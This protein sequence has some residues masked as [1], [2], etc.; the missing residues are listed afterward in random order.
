MKKLI[1]A[2][3]V[4]FIGCIGSPEPRNPMVSDGVA[5]VGS[6]IWWRQPS[7]AGDPDNPWEQF[8]PQQ[9][10][11]WHDPWGDFDPEEYDIK[12]IEDKEV[13]KFTFRDE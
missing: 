3:M 9:Q 7:I 5:S 10:Q 2:C 12:P 11:K 4:L 1:L 13:I 6:E 8:V